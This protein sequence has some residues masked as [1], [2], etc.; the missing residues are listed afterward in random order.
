[1]TNIIDGGPIYCSEDV[2]LKGTIEEI[3]ARVREASERLITIIITDNPTPVPQSGTPINFR[4]RQ[5]KDSELPFSGTLESLFDHIRMLDA[6]GYPSA[7]IEAKGYRLEFSKAI[8]DKTLT[9][10]V[11]I[12]PIRE[13][14]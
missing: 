3:F 7:F 5:P 4:R 2:S 8:Y 11:R 9:A 10:E 14:L 6:P 12:T 13:E 1:M